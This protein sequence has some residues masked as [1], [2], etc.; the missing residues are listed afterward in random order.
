MQQ[1]DH[2]RIF[3]GLSGG[4]DSSVAAALLKEGGHDVTGVFIKG[5]HPEWVECSWKEDRA[6]AMRVA[7]HLGIPVHTLDLSREYE[8]DVAGYMIAEYRAGRTP[9]PDVMCNREIKFGAFL[10]WSLAQGADAIATG[11]YARIREKS[12]IKNQKPETKYEL[13]RGADAGKDQSYFLWTLAQEQLARTL[14]PVGGMAKPQVR[15]LAQRYG[16]PTA[17][18]RDSQGVC[19]LG[20]VELSAFLR[21]YID[22]HQGA[23][24][25]ERGE[26]VGRHDGVEFYTLG[27]R[28]GFTVAQKTP[29]DAPYYIVGKDMEHNTLTVSHDQ[30]PLSAQQTRYTL[31]QLN[32]DASIQEGERY[33]AQYRYRQQPKSCAVTGLA[34]GRMEIE[35]D[36]PQLAAAGQSLVLYR[37]DAVLGGGVIA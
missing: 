4:V 31:R 36:E 18:K 28:H 8:R 25:N 9:N 17:R 7:A 20:A 30:L 23:V 34:A 21:R 32:Q 14:F 5:W 2:T 1:R 24:L 22:P 27:E 10:D 37:G 35:F 16:L 33:E 15:E 11:H 6:D 29:H 19:F 3:V 26:T 12:K 13:L